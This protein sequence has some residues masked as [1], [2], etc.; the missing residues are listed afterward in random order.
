[1]KTLSHDGGNDSSFDTE[2]EGAAAPSFHI[3]ILKLIMKLTIP[4][5]PIPIY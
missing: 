4:V 5:Y 3:I 1:M 2:K